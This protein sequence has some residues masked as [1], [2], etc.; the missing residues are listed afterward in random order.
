MSLT[1]KNAVIH[2]VIKEENSIANIDLSDEQLNSSDENINLLMD[3]LD[4]I[5]QKRTPKRAKLLDDSLFKKL[6]DNDEV[7]LL[8]ESGELIKELK[9]Q[10]INLSQSK[11]GYFLFVEYKSINNFL[12]V[13]ILRN[14]NGFIS[15][16]ESNH[17]VLERV[18]HLDINKLAMG[19]RIN[20]DIYNNSE[21][22]DRKKRYVLLIRG[23]TDISKYFDN[24]I[25]INDARMESVDATSLMQIA[26]YIDLPNGVQ[27]RK[28][29]R[30]KIGEFAS[31]SPNNKVNLTALSLSVFGNDTY[32]AE[33]CNTNE[34]DIDDEFKISKANIKKFYNIIVNTD[35]IKLSFSR[36]KIND[37]ISINGNKVIINSSSLAQEIS[38]QITNE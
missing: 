11:G 28:E 2:E 18:T 21:N 10:L 5:F 9:S 32:L 26:S 19:M 22:E 29:L 8:K 13:F 4:N 16:N 17:F 6:I 7:G 1:I 33:Y 35:G 38:S 23:T 36:D 24:W 37:S 25:G 3:K 14:T 34:I 31:N 20:L 27:D 30:R 15:K 12:A